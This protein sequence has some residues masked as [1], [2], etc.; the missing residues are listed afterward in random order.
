MKTNSNPG[1]AVGIASLGRV[2]FAVTLIGLGISG[3]IRG[4]FDPMWLPVS[5]GTPGREVL[6]YLSALISL[7]SGVGLLWRRS[8]AVASGMLLAFLLAWLLLM[9][10]PHIVLAPGIQT[11][12][13]ACKTAVMAAAAWVLYVSFAGNSTVRLA[14]RKVR[15]APAAIAGDTGLRVARALYG[16]A[17]IPFG[18]AHFRYLERTASMVPGWLPAHLAWAYFTGGALIAAGVAILIGVFARLAAALSALELALFTLLVWVPVVAAGPN[19]GQWTESTVS[20]A[21]TASAWVVADSYRG[22]PWF[23]VRRG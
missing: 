7:A 18:L 9:R 8:A 3:L 21:L 2:V 13:A 22:M 4:N 10:V 1:S 14:T 19:A 17:L 12:W 6:V 15:G 11:V 23:A 20:W 16:A 5:K